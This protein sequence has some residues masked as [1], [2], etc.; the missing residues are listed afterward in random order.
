M[1]RRPRK[2]AYATLGQ[3][4]QRPANRTARPIPLFDPWQPAEPQ[5]S[6]R[7]MGH[8]ESTPGPL[9]ILLVCSPGGHAL[10]LSLLRPAWEGYETAWV[11]LRAE[12]TASLFED[13][14]VVY[15]HGPTTRNIPN[16]LR[17]LRLASRILRAARPKVI[18]TTGA[19]LAVPFAWIGRVLGARVVYIESFTRIE[20]ASLSGR[21]VAPVADRFY[22]QWPELARSMRRARYTG[23]VIGSL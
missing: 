2:R 4:W 6:L 10:Q 5:P 20:R 3:R 13:E 12:D 15:A 11:T 8:D 21:L 18:V 17:N 22:V 9:D 7:S 19:G 16:L 1:L 14:R 23:T